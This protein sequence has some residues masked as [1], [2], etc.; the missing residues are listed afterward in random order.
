MNNIEKCFDS[1]L[2]DESKKMIQHHK[3]QIEYS[4]E[5]LKKIERQQLKEYRE[6]N[7]NIPTD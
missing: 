5:C 1:Y 4:K 6:A 2:T 3:D 7:K